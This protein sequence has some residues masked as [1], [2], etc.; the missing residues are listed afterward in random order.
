MAI[1][2]V[3]CNNLEY[4]NTMKRLLP[5]LALLMAGCV[6]D[7]VTGVNPAA[8]DDIGFTVAV[9]RASVADAEA[10]QGD[11]AGFRVWALNGDDPSGWY[12]DGV[13]AI[14]GENPHIYDGTRWAFADPVKWPGI[15]G[16]PMRFWALYPASPAGLG[17][18]RSNFLP[19]FSL[20]ADY[21]VQPTAAMQSDLLAASGSAKAKPL[22][23]TMP[24]TFEHILS[25]IDFGIITGHDVN[26]HIQSIEL[27]NAASRG[28]YD[29][30]TREWNTP[31]SGYTSYT[32]LREDSEDGILACWPYGEI[33]HDDH[34]ANPVYTGSEA[35]G[36]HLMLMP[37]RSK[38]WVP[39]AG[40]LPSAGSGAY[41][42]ITYRADM[43]DEQG[44]TIRKTGYIDASDHPD[45]DGSMTG[46]LFVK[47]GFPLPA[48]EDGNFVWEAGKS[49]CY[50]IGINTPGSSGGYILDECYYDERGDRTD[51]KL[52]RIRDEGRL[53][54]D[55]L[56]DGLIHVTLQMR[57]WDV[58]VKDIFRSWPRL[59]PDN[60]RIPQTDQTPVKESIEVLF[61]ENGTAGNQRPWTLTS[62]SPSWLT[63]SLSPNGQNAAATVSGDGPARVYLVSRAN[64]TGRF[65][66]AT[67]YGG[68]DPTDIM[69]T[70]SQNLKVEHISGSGTAPVGFTT[71]VG[72]FWRH[73]Q[74]G[75]RVIRLTNAGLTATNQGAWSAEV[76]WMDSRWGEDDGIILAPGDSKALTVGTDNLTPYDAN[77]ENFLVPGNSA[78]VSGRIDNVNKDIVFR[79]G[80]KS[81]Y[82]PTVAHPARYAVVLITYG[83]DKTQ[84]LFLRQGE[85]DDYLMAPSDPASTGA[86]T[87]AVKFSPYNLK[88]STL[89]SPVDVSGTYPAVNPGYFTDFP[90]QAGV[91]FQ[92][93]ATDT[94]ERLAWPPIGYSVT[95]WASSYST[96]YWSPIASTQET[97]PAG[98]RRPTDGSTSAAESGNVANSEV[99]HS[100]WSLPKAGLF[101]SDK[102]N[103]FWGYYA[104]GYFD[105]RLIVN[106]ADATLS[107]VSYT[108]NNA[109][110]IGCLFFNPTTDSD[111]YNASL[112]FP[113]G[114]W[115]DAAGTLVGS[116]RGGHY[117]TSSA[118]SD[119]NAWILWIRNDWFAGLWY[120]LKSYGRYIRCVRNTP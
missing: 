82:K 47:T 8:S 107:A 24:L 103:N 30:V 15:D 108:K 113:A 62:S 29:F 59:S 69:A 105:R 5:A 99:R 45:Y 95:N 9:T 71:Y 17:A 87:N 83:G 119:I 109:A 6:K 32:Y 25:K 90:S 85:H 38:S 100:L 60:L 51:F 104:D 55:P 53:E 63:L 68:N 92:W 44:E 7:N 22:M 73:N 4:N 1:F 35:A 94:R 23:S 86:R 16:F 12:S 89:Y 111:H 21:N 70:V 67:L 88:A 33:V 117:W 40:T 72:A 61:P 110:Y 20:R 102:T 46:P 36:R 58:S 64:N 42:A 14:D 56:R 96:S 27:V 39:V 79:I 31:A 34:I 115:R 54:G 78:F 101:G 48:D 3:L 57:A 66:T 37:Q 50:N 77:A 118:L 112:F 2:S 93:A 10:I 26:V 120:D 116:G 91:F 18:V 52:I 74:I 80:L 75:E 97:C 76:A 43:V 98:Y 13:N 114:G 106:T 81:A 49:Y 84:K 28:T 11:A 65:R 41:V 19:E